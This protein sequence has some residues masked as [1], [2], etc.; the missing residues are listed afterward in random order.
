MRPIPG[1]KNYKVK[2][3]ICFHL[4]YFIISFLLLSPES[5]SFS[6]SLHRATVNFQ[7][8]TTYHAPPSTTASSPEWFSSFFSYLYHSPVQI[9]SGGLDHSGTLHAQRPWCHLHQ[10]WAEN[11]VNIRTNS[12]TTSGHSRKTSKKHIFFT[13][14]NAPKRFI[15]SCFVLS[16]SKKCLSAVIPHWF[17]NIT[18]GVWANPVGSHIPDVSRELSHKQ[19]HTRATLRTKQDGHKKKKNVH[20]PHWWVTPPGYVPQ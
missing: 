14:I 3:P 19:P 18:R 6:L 4:V 17:H 7:L 2:F 12:E 20:V 11:E 8:P 9:H 16:Q 1:L 15:C 10:T 5:S 13:H